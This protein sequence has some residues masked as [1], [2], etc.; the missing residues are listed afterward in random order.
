[1][2]QSV[3]FMIMNGIVINLVTLLYSV[4]IGGI[5]LKRPGRVG[6]AA[7]YGSGVWADSYDPDDASIAVCTT[8][9]GEYLMQTLLAK[10]IATDLK[11]STFPTIELHSSMTE[12]FLS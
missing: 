4:L 2:I 8:G 5:L 7:L 10:E 6:Q 11:Q 1:M 3:N 9:C 12:K